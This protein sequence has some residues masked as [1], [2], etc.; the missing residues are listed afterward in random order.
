MT[1]KLTQINKL[2]RDI[3]LINQTVGKTL[4]QIPP[5]GMM[6]AEKRMK[7]MAIVNQIENL[8]K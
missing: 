4:D 8:T 7:I 5:K 1:E 2:C 3:K 6:P